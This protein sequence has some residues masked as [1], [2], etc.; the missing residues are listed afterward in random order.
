MSGRAFLNTLQ[1]RAGPIAFLPQPYSILFAC[2]SISEKGREQS[3]TLLRTPK[4]DA[5]AHCFLSGTRRVT[6][7]IIPSRVKPLGVSQVPAS[8]AEPERVT[9]L[10]AVTRGTGSP[11]PGLHLVEVTYLRRL[12]LRSSLLAKCPQS[13]PRCS[14]TS[15]QSWP[16]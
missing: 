5:H 4:E 3:E 10:P 11:R 1:T 9:Y 13:L 6:Q 14:G 8:C 12:K 15:L 16:M 2:V 7:R